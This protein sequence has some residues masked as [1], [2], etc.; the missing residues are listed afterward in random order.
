MISSS[1]V[2]YLFIAFAFVLLLTGNPY[3]ATGFLAMAIAVV[4]II[5]AFVGLYINR[6]NNE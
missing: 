5:I 4:A 1:I 3:T 6:K 2:Y